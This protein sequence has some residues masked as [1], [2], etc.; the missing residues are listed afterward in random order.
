MIGYLILAVVE[1]SNIYVTG[2]LVMIM[3]TILGMG[4]TLYWVRI[5]K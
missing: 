5:K 2:L 1:N 4:V 3:S